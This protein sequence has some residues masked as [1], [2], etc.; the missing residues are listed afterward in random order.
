MLMSRALLETFLDLSDHPGPTLERLLDDVGLEVKGA[1]PAGGDTL[2][3][4]EIL[5][6]RGDHASRPRV[7]TELSGRLLRPVRFPDLADLPA[8]PA[9]LPVGIETPLCA[10]YSLLEI[11]SLPHEE[12][13]REIAALLQRLG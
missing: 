11:P 5:A 12:T 9:S 1:E 10:R 2:Y 6:N 8:R 13:P 4:L 3:H 7:A